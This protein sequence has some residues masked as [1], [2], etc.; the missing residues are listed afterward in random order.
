MR[1]CERSLLAYVFPG[2]VYYLFFFAET[3]LEVR[4]LR[5]SLS[6]WLNGRSGCP[7]LT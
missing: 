4:I 6:Q 1:C 2:A 5:G 7:A 3:S